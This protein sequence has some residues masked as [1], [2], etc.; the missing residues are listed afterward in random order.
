M[1]EKA[2][3]TTG[4]SPSTDHHTTADDAPYPPPGGY[5][6]RGTSTVPEP[7][8]ESQARII[9][10]LT[11]VSA[12]FF[13]FIGPLVALLVFKGRSPLVEHHAKEQLN[14]AI[15]LFFYMILAVVGTIATLGLALVAVVPA[16]V[17]VP[18]AAVVLTIVAA[19]SAGSGE[20]YRFPFIV[21][22][23]P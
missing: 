22:L 21:R 11:H 8:W 14:L 7:L 23:I 18:I 9:A 13:P 1:S 10:A 19:F 6:A 20:Y 3:G 5:A 16:L 17:V 2:T 4:T 12:F 15:S